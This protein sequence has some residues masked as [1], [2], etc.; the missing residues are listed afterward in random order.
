MQQHQGFHGLLFYISAIGIIL[1][2]SFR[3]IKEQNDIQ[4][5]FTFSI[6][7]YLVSAMFGNSMYYTSPYYFVLLG[8]LF[9]YT[10]NFED[11]DIVN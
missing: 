5:V 3:N 2:R 1:W 10:I 11:T 4:I 8:F 6:I 7:A 9:R